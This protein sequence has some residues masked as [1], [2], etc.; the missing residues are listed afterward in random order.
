MN[1]PG[2]HRHRRWHRRAAFVPW[3]KGDVE[4]IW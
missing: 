2:L 1:P 4:N 3:T